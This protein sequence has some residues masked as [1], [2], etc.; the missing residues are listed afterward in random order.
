MYVVDRLR[1]RDTEFHLQ[2]PYS[3]DIDRDIAEFS[4]T[5]MIFGNALDDLFVLLKKHGIESKTGSAKKL[6]QHEMNYL[7]VSFILLKD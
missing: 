2:N 6:E 5:H 3:C 4:S 1:F 7:H